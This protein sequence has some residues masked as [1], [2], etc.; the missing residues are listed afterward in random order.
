M[1]NGAN[2]NHPTIKPRKI[3]VLLLNL[4]TPDA[5][6]YFSMRRYLSEFLSDKRVIDYPSWFW[7]PLLQGIILTSRPF[8]SGAAYRKIWNNE[9]NES[10]LK[11]YT[12]SQ[13]EKI[14]QN[15]SGKYPQMEFEWGMR[16][17]N[18]STQKGI[19]ALIEKGCDRIL[20]FALY[21]QYS[22]CTSATAYDKAFDHLKTK[23][24]QPAIRTAE[25]WHDDAGYIKILSNTVKEALSAAQ[26]KPE[27]II[28]SF[29]GLPKRYLMNGD[30]YH[31]YCAKT[32]RL[33]RE[34]MGWSEENWTCTFQSRFGPE[35][36]LQP[37]TDETV[38]ELA[39]K[40][41]K[42]I[43]VISPAF[44]S[45]CVETLEELQLELKEEFLHNG[46]ETFT[47]IPCLNDRDDHIAFLASRIEKELAGWV[48]GL[49]LLPYGIP[50]G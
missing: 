38:V 15:L 10:P 4:G 9:R 32:S 47:Y 11:T 25:Q 26:S 36:W 33:L 3:G 43:A 21:P 8:R 24:R 2:N 7:Q 30:P 5:T 12:R 20:F 23:N 35:E 27:H 41:I 29:H 31:C 18:P 6:D 42:H 46:G 39:K 40:G 13:C 50:T 1:K 14:A 37:Y 48:Q 22:A 28:A 19:D 45:E 34:S 49:R 44:V 16:Y 17:G